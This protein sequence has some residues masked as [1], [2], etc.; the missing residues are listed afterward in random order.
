MKILATIAQSNSS[1][2]SA[3]GLADL[4][5]QALIEQVNALTNQ[6]RFNGAAL[7]DGNSGDPTTA[8]TY[9]S[10][11]ADMERILGASFNNV[12]DT[13][14]NMTDADAETLFGKGKVAA[15]VT[16]SDVISM[17]KQLEGTG[18]ANETLATGFYGNIILDGT[19][20]TSFG[21]LDYAGN[22]IVN[23]TDS[24][25]S[26]AAGTPTFTDLL[27][28]FTKGDNLGDALDPNYSVE[29]LINTDVSTDVLKLD[30]GSIDT[31][32]LLIDGTNI[33]TISTAQTAGELLNDALAHIRELQATLGAFQSRLNYTSSNL[34]QSIENGKAAKSSFVDA[35]VADEMI[36][37]TRHEML[38][39]MSLSNLA[40]TFRA[41]KE[42]AQFAQNN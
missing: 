38:A 18:H 9:S 41:L 36:G 15:D 20:A 37:K 8:G 33:Q 27:N 32:R 39:G 11:Q 13:A 16:V 12:N 6:T 2:D 29:F 21:V 42:V 40:S 14:T 30:I 35:N 17:H 28:A 22:S 24:D 5:Y 34:A 19:T 7:I 31:S 3:R 10:F 26:G 23:T 1:D 4:E 25:W